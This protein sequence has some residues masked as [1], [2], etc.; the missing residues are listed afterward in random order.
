[1]TKITL[2]GLLMDLKY[3]LSTFPQCLKDNQKLA[4]IKTKGEFLPLGHTV[5]P[6]AAQPYRPTSK[7]EAVNLGGRPGVIQCGCSL[8]WLISPLEMAPKYISREISKDRS[9]VEHSIPNA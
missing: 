3:A 9:Q 4:L 5:L 8:G 1:M 2:F 6:P 7:W